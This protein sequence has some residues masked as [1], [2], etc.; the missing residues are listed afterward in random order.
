MQDTALNF[1]T[2]LE[3]GI[4]P[5]ADLSFMMPLIITS[6]AISALLTVL[7]LVYVIFNT[8][9]R[10]KVEKATFDMQKD[11]RRMRELMEQGST[12]SPITSHSTKDLLA[13]HTAPV[14]EDPANDTVL[15]QIESK[16]VEQK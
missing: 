2:G 13:H 3:Q 14:D 4:A 1:E 6:I 10:Y 5:G 12:P 15:T 9:R 16:E 8:V 7:F 11:I